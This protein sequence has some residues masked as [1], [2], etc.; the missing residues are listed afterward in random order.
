MWLERNFAWSLGM[1]NFEIQTL[2]KVL[3]NEDELTAQEEQTVE[4][5]AENI[6][7]TY[8]DKTRTKVKM[9]PSG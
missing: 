5:L 9:S 3:K 2:I 4:R 6:E 7:K 1:T 8:E